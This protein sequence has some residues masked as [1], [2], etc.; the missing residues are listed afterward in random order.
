MARPIGKESAR[1]AGFGVLTAI[2]LWPL[3]QVIGSHVLKAIYY[4][5]AYT[6]AMAMSGR[7]R[8]VLG[9]GPGSHYTSYFFAPI[10]DS[11]VF[12]ESLFGLSL[13]YAPFELITD[14]P[15]AAY[16][17]T[18]LL[19]FTLSQYFTY[20]LV[21]RLTGNGWAGAL[22]GFLFAFS[23]YATFEM[24]RIQL[25]ATQWIPLLWLF[26]HRLTT[27]RRIRDL[28]GLC[29][30][31]LLQ[32]GTCLYYAMFMAPLLALFLLT[33]LVQRPLPGRFWLRSVPV[34]L[35][36]GLLALLMT[37]PYF[38][39]RKGFQLERAESFA[40]SF[41][42]ELGFFLNVH[43]T[44]RT[45]TGMHHRSYE[46]G[47]HEEI[48][49]P[50]F[51]GFGL[52]V[53]SLLSAFVAF[54]RSRGRRALAQWSALLLATFALA[55]LSSAL[56]H[57]AL[58]GALAF[59]LSIPIGL[60]AGID[61]PFPTM[62]RLWLWVLGLSLALYLGMF[63]FEWG[64]EP[65]AGLYYYLH[66][67][68]PGFN[69]IRKVSRQACMTTFLILVI[70]GYGGRILFQA[71][72]SRPW[73]V[74]S[75]A[76]L[77]SLSAFE[78]RTFPNEVDPLWAGST[79]PAAYRF[80]GEQPGTAP[81][82]IYPAYFGKERFRRHRGMALHNYMALH[83]R[84]RTLNGKSSFIPPVTHLTHQALRALPRQE[85]LR[86]L[87]ILA[88]EFLLLHTED[89]SR[90]RALMVVQGL[91][92]RTDAVARVF[93]D[94]DQYVYRMLPQ[95]DP[96]LGLLTVP[97]IPK[98]T[99]A[100]APSAMTASRSAQKTTPERAR[101]GD[102]RSVWASGRNM[103]RGDYVEL[104]LARPERVAMVQL[105]S[106]TAPTDHPFSFR[107]EVE[108]PSGALRT[109]V[110]RPRIRLFSELVYAPNRFH[111]R[112][113]L[114]E[115]T[116]TQRVRITVLEPTPARWWSIGEAT[117]FVSQVP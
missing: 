48:A 30:T 97:P 16:N 91:D 35:C 12:N 77:L 109:V 54:A 83:H 4:W 94:G 17:I 11:I 18:L 63:P 81:V 78:L 55:L 86:V 59:G 104:H 26:A 3:P 29:A 7:L 90:A 114:P 64:G 28:A 65:V 110:N 15:L 103:H 98:S 85:G 102:P 51:T 22:C 41:D 47:A 111:F 112:I 66:T 53:L 75:F 61:S 115:P 50:S 14:S 105:E 34:I 92:R 73:Q 42:G 57:T 101:D 60:R 32:V 2:M 69:G 10:N 40:A 79:V 56:T 67:Y 80:I 96:S 33:R 27:E 9:T 113:P 84:R 89:V 37:Y 62:Q 88:P 108:D 24:G 46:R 19:S 31:Y 52:A 70:A 13:I 45:L 23:P 106:P 116:L 1:I 72:P 74:M 43:D 49:F 117:L 8:N 21:K 39:S 20:L 95:D 58:A 44:N 6:N 99:R 107:V 5:D 93:R 100:L 76:L 87:Q 38:T 36:A 82:A 25:V 68:L 71:V